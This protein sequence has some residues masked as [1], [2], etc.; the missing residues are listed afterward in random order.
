MKKFFKVCVAVLVFIPCVIIDFTQALTEGAPGA[1]IKR[2][3][4]PKVHAWAE[5]R[6]KN[7]G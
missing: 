1:A 5:I 7:P 6:R 2:L 3:L 4:L